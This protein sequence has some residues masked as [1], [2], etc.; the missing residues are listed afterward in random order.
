M[1]INAIYDEIRE[2][3]GNNVKFSESIIPNASKIY[4]VRISE[5]RKLAKKIAKEDHQKFLQ[6]NPMDSYEMEMLHGMVIGYAKDEIGN[7]LSYI[8]AFIPKIHDWSV[9]DTLCQTFKICRKYLK[10]TWD[11][12][13]KYRESENEFEIRVVSVMLMSHFLV[14]EYIDE[15]IKVLDSYIIKE[16]QYYA[17]MGVAWAIAT[18]MAKY[19]EKC[20]EYLEN[21]N[22]NLDDWTYNKSIQKMRE[23]FRVSKE[24]KEYIVKLKKSN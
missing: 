13:M 17:K 21:P 22:N 20:L 4:G 7:L 12:L 23:S 5:L 2:L 14:D 15:V 6:E 24:I 11:F 1:E 9:N 8:E 10:E 3:S 16:D 19:P 18:I